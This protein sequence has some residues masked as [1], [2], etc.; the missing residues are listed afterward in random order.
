MK[1]LEADELHFRLD[2]IDERFEGTFDWIFN[3]T[4]PGFTEWLQ[5]GSGIFWINGKPGSGKSTLMKS[6]VQAQQTRDYLLSW[7]SDDPYLV[8]SF[9]FHHRGS[10]IQKSFEGLLRSVLAQILLHSE[11]LWLMAL[12]KFGTD[13][14]LDTAVLNEGKFWTL[15]RLKTWVRCILE[16]TEVPMHVVL[17][18]DALDEFDGPKEFICDF[19]KHIS[20]MPQTAS[21]NVKVCFSSRPWKI[22]L[23]NFSTCPGFR[24][25]D[26]TGDDIRDFCVGS[27]R[28]R[29][30]ETRSLVELVPEI[31]A[32]SEGVFLWIKLVIRELTAELNGGSNVENL[33]KRLYDFPT[34]LDEYYNEII[35]RIPKGDRWRTYM[36]LEIMA[37]IDMSIEPENL[38]NAVDTLQL[39][40]QPEGVSRRRL[41]VTDHNEA[42]LARLAQNGGGLLEILRAYDGSLVV[43]FIHQTVRDFVVDP[44][45]KR[46]V[47]GGQADFTTSNGYTFLAQAGFLL[48]QWLS[49]REDTAFYCYLAEQTTGQSLKSFIDHM[50]SS[51]ALDLAH[52]LSS[53]YHSLLEFAVCSTL[54][55]YVNDLVEESPG[56]LKESREKLFTALALDHSDF[57]SRPRETGIQAKEMATFLLKCGYRVEED[58]DCLSTALSTKGVYY[59]LQLAQL[60]ALTVP[61]VNRGHSIT[62]LT[63]VDALCCLID[64]FPRSIEGLEYMR[65]CYQILL[66]LIE[67][68]G[69][70][71]TTDFHTRRRVRKK[72]A[73]FEMSSKIIDDGLGTSW[74]HFLE[75]HKSLAFDQ[76]GH[77]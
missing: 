64:V 18:L 17:F 19:L 42:V 27:I 10:P 54:F 74:V 36:T 8:A 3:T 44:N 6:I 48:P 50:V 5:N 49:L 66:T 28:N 26:F 58:P 45:F 46:R 35:Q 13:L 16:Q 25:Q 73:R 61:D 9:F 68:G 33:K 67:R 70:Y 24:L 59:N 22:F 7:K 69:K 12:S 71:R 41:N 39:H 76:A 47:L 56:I 60:L 29:G 1:S 62:G 2:T 72:F 63:P 38:F 40:S 75:I 51:G 14:P 43:Q 32:K 53:H 55:R 34:E 21:K 31:V 15:H 65:T 30:T 52:T 4:K 11:S 37:R 57:R 20:G 77:L 23:A